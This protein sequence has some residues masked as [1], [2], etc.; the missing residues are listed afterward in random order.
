MPTR[1]GASWRNWTT[2]KE[3]TA[4]GVS[5]TAKVKHLPRRDLPRPAGADRHQSVALEDPHT[6]PEEGD[7]Q[8]RGGPSRESV[9]S[10]RRRSRARQV[11]CA[12]VVPRSVRRA[13]RPDGALRCDPGVGDE[14]RERP[15]RDRLVRQHGS[16][17]GCERERGGRMP[18]REGAA[19]RHPGSARREQPARVR[20]PAPSERL[21]H[22]VGSDRRDGD[23]RKPSDSRVPSGRATGAA[24]ERRAAE[25]HPSSSRLHG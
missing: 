22:E 3:T 19:I 21:E 13:H 24:E 1:A 14:G 10:Q 20:T 2:R 15:D 17:P 6:R 9:S 7:R 18:R 4:A 12:S 25:P 8:P 16:D 11:S 5:L 23:G